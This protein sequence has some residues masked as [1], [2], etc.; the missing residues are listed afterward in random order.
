[1][2][3]G[4]RTVEG[5]GTHGDSPAPGPGVEGAGAGVESDGAPT[6]RHVE[7]PDAPA[8]STSPAPRPGVEGSA[9]H[10]TGDGS[11][12]ESEGPAI[13]T[14]QKHRLPTRAGK[15]IAAAAVA[16][17]C[18]AMYLDCADGVFLAGASTA[19]ALIAYWL[20]EHELGQGG[21]GR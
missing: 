14:T 15:V 1:M 16:A 5:S 10:S 21:G 13:T 8:A 4:A 20:A 7:G 12:P 9:D 18:G 6:C 3:A 17:F 19:L 2:R 11:R